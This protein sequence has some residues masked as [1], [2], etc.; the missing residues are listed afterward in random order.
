MKVKELIAK[1]ERLEPNLDVLAYW[2]TDDNFQLLDLVDVDVGKAVVERG[3]DRV[4][5][6]RFDDDSGRPFAWLNLTAD[7]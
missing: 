3:E 6:V 5:R 7:M 2:E 1:L 4:A